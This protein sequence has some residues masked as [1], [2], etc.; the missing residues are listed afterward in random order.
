[1]GLSGSYIPPGQ[2]V[3]AGICPI[4]LAPLSAD[5]ESIVCAEC[6]WRPIEINTEGGDE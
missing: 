5:E 2:H 1:M 4:C 6:G 3:A